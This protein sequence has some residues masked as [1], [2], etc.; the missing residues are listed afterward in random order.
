MDNSGT[1]CVGVVQVHCGAGGAVPGRLAA[2]GPHALHVRPAVRHQHRG[3]RLPLRAGPRHPH[4]RH[5][6]PSPAHA[7]LQAICMQRTVVAWCSQ[8]AARDHHRGMRQPFVRRSDAICCR[9]NM[10]ALV[11]CVHLGGHRRRRAARGAGEGRRCVGTRQPGV[12]GGLRQDWHPDLR[13]HGCHVRPH[14]R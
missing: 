13:P 5:G 10:K 6:A 7:L 8:A 2:G 11:F 9:Q 12:R 3:G 1:S 4:R 14:L